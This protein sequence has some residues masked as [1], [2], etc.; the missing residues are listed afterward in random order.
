MPHYNTVVNYMNKFKTKNKSL[1]LLSR[2]PDAYKSKYKL[3]LGNMAEEATEVNYMWELDSTP[4]DIILKE[5]RVTILGCIDIYSRRIKFLVEKTSNSLGISNLI[6]QCVIDWGVPKIIKTDNGKDYT[7]QQIKVVLSK[8]NVEQRLTRPFSG[9]EKPFIERA[10]KTL[11][12]GMMEI[13]KDFIGHNVAER[14]ALNAV[15]TFA[16]RMFNKD[17]NLPEL[18]IDDFQRFLTGWSDKYYLNKPHQGINRQT[19]ASRLIGYKKQEYL[20][21]RDLDLLL[22]PLAGYRT[23]GKKGI[24]VENA[25]YFEPNLANHVGDKVQVRVDRFDM[26]KIY[27]FDEAHNFISEAVNYDLLGEDKLKFIAKSKAIQGQLNKQFKNKTKKLIGK[28]KERNKM[29]IRDI[30]L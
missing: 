17:K 16:E 6:R 11:P 4:A 14:K 10:F 30:G 27:I 9:E 19:P 29:A 20:T 25:N 5:G 12:H 22:E 2:N 15:Q 28:C 3:A 13:H 26:G 24:K 8:L 1:Y 23:I 18:S 21:I 7:S